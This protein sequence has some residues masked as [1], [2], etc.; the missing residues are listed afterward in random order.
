LIGAA[1]HQNNVRTD[2]ADAV[3]GDYKLIVSACHSEKP[4]GTGDDQCRYAAVR[5]IDFHIRY[6][7]Q[8]P[9]VTDADHLF[10]VQIRD[11]GSHSKPPRK[12]ILGK[13]MQLPARVCHFLVSEQEKCEEIRIH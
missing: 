8:P 6:K 7:P 11:P 12:I 5:H 3:P 1:L 9:T 13:S 4:A 10:T 2:A